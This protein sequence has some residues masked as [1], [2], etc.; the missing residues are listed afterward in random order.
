[1]H[2]KQLGLSCI[3]LWVHSEVQKNSAIFAAYSKKTIK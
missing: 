3:F 2:D 1:M